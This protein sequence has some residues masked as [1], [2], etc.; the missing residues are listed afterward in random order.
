[1]GSDDGSFWPRTGEL[2]AVVLKRSQALESPEEERLLMAS[3]MC[4][5]ARPPFL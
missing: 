5:R 3:R 1:M 2:V 4:S